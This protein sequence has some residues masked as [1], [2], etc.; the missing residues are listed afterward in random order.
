MNERNICKLYTPSMADPIR[1][2][3]F[4][5]ESSPEKITHFVPD[6]ERNKMLLVTQGSGALC[7]NGQSFGYTTGTLLFLFR[8]DSVSLPET[9]DSHFMYVDFS[10]QRADDL[11]RRFGIHEGNRIFQGFGGMIPLWKE[12]LLR[13]SAETIDLAAEGVLLHT[14]SRM[15]REKSE[16]NE[17][18]AAIIRIVTVKHIKISDLV[19]DRAMEIA[20]RH[21]QLVEVTK[22]GQISRNV[23]H[24][25]LH[26]ADTT[27]QVYFHAKNGFAHRNSHHRRNQDV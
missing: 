15:R 20:V 17:T 16:R 21:G 1:I 26:S 25:D 10:G 18:V 24:N 2:H 7:I 5:Y 23:F 11:L 14:L 9:E 22:H 3:C 13:A 6:L 8:G 27:A 4:V 19:A 12:C